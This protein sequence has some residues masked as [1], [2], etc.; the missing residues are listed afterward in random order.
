MFSGEKSVAFFAKTLEIPT[1]TE[2]AV[3]RLQEFEEEDLDSESKFQEY[4][5]EKDAPLRLIFTVVQL[6][7]VSSI[8]QIGIPFSLYSKKFELFA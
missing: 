6:L 8:D 7:A 3:F 1:G 2:S 5:L 4:E